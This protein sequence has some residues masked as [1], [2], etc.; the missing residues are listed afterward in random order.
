MLTEAQITEILA[1]AVADQSHRAG[2]RKG[3]NAAVKLLKSHTAQADLPLPPGR[4]LET[5]LAEIGSF[6]E[7]EVGHWT[8]LV[9]C[10]AG[11]MNRAVLVAVPDGEVLHL[12]AWAKE[13]LINQHSAEKALEKLKA[14]LL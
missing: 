5:A 2:G 14:A 9:P 6:L 7:R 3:G 12:R 1:K 8:V 4:D 11:N 13:G 10:G